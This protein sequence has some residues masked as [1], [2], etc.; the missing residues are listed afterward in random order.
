MKAKVSIIVICYNMNRELPRTLLSLSLPYQKDIERDDFEVILI[1]N[2]SKIP[3]TSADFAHLNLDLR[4][5]S[6]ANPT[7]ARCLRLI[8]A[9]NKLLAKSSVCISMVLESLLHG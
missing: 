9:S 3:P 6:M 2:G 8:S 5:L 4:V 1:D 7:R